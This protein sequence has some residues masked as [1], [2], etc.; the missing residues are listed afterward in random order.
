MES[1]LAKIGLKRD[2]V[3]SMEPTTIN[4]EIQ[5]ARNQNHGALLPMVIR[6]Q[7]LDFVMFKSATLILN[8]TLTLKKATSWA[9]LEPVLM[10]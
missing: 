4:A 2:L 5:V 7:K 8:Q 10:I 9:I 3:Q 6:D 1:E